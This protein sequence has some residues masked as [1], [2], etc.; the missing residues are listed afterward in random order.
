MGGL[1]RCCLPIFKPKYPRVLV[2]KHCSS[3]QH[4]LTILA[5]IPYGAATRVQRFRLHSF[6]VRI[7]IENIDKSIPFL[8]LAHGG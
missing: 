4:I 6:S 1:G 5:R 7:A 2:A 3:S 8:L